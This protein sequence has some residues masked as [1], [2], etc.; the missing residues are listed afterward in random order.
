MREVELLEADG[1]LCGEDGPGGGAVDGYVGGLMGPE[2]IAVDGDG[3]VEGGGK[4]VLGGQAVEDGDDPC[5]GEVCNGD[6]FGER[7]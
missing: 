6:A 3:V 5:V 2:E 1:D 4:G 7:S